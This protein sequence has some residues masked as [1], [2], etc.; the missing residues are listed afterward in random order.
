ML[1]SNNSRSAAATAVKQPDISMFVRVT[2]PEKILAIASASGH[3]GETLSVARSGLMKVE[4]VA[5]PAADSAEVKTKLKIFLKGPKGLR[6]VNEADFPTPLVDADTD[7]CQGPRLVYGDPSSGVSFCIMVRAGSGPKKIGSKD[8]PAIAQRQLDVTRNLV[9]NVHPGVLMTD[10]PDFAGWFENGYREASAM[11]PL[12]HTAIQRDGVL[13]YYIAG[14]KDGH[15]HVGDPGA[16]SALWAGWRAEFQGERLVVAFSSKQWGAPMPPVGSVVESCDGKSAQSILFEDVAPFS[17]RHTDFAEV[18]KRLA[19]NLSL[20]GGRALTR[21]LARY[22]RFALP[23]GTSKRLPTRW[24]KFLVEELPYESLEPDTFKP[25]DFS[26]TDLGGGRFWVRIPTFAVDAQQLHQVEAIEKQ[27][28]QLGNARWLVFD[29]R[30]NQGGDSG[31]G[32]RMLNALT[33]GL[34]PQPTPQ[35]LAGA[36]QAKALWRVSQ[37]TLAELESGGAAALAQKGPDHPATVFYTQM[38]AKYRDAIGSGEVWVEQP[39]DPL[40]TR[41]QVSAW[42]LSPARFKGEVVVLTDGFCFSAC[43][44][45]L[46]EALVYPDVEHWGKT[47]SADTRYIDVG[48]Y[49]IAPNLTLQMPRKV[50][51]LRD[52][53]NNIPFVPSESYAGDMND[54]AAV[55]E[56]VLARFDK[57]EASTKAH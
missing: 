9:Q 16:A 5:T 22:C 25:E 21:K 8:W 39:G 12:V 55:R 41:Q 11:T 18:R 4:M 45:F 42:G 57:D 29:V 38:A 46:G 34:N 17:D 40:L 27:L 15:F 56:W 20:T 33:G 24:K 54:S 32:S 51:T 44:D 30:G 47:T 13:E 6:L 28:E 1:F 26:L 35:Q 3:F 10:D 52:R 43:L 36:P 48:V 50:W 49:E 31:I 14:F 53:G 37:E 19:A 2:K 23:N 7:P